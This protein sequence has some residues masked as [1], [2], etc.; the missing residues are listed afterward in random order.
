M[1]ENLV[2]YIQLPHSWLTPNLTLTLLQIPSC[3]YKAQPGECTWWQS[4]LKAR[5]KKSVCG[6]CRSGDSVEGTSA[7]V[8]MDELKQ[9]AAT[10]LSLMD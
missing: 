7:A 3:L 10:W 1:R 6:V 4:T 2:K 8:N 5:Q 9:D